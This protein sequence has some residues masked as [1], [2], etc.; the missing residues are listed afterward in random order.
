M[1]IYSPHLRSSLTRRM[2]FLAR[3]SDGYE[4]GG[5]SSLYIPKLGFQ[6][7]NALE[8]VANTLA[9]RL[10]SNSRSMEMATFTAMAWHSGSPNSA[11]LLVLYSAASTPLRGSASSS[12]PTRT[13]AQAPSSPMLWLWSATARKSTTSRTT[14]RTMSSW[15]VRLAVSEV[16]QSLLRPN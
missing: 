7:P 4:L 13:I 16:H 11:L 15:D 9:N 14:E 5:W 3:A 2:D 10:K 8:Q 1:Q 6:S 12:T